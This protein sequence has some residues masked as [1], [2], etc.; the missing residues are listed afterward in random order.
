LQP[1]RCAPQDRDHPQLE[2][3][4]FRLEVLDP[5]ALLEQ[6]FGCAACSLALVSVQ[7]NCSPR[8]KLQASI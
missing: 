1:R 6:P 5:A 2:G 4:V 8:Q 3:S 7:S